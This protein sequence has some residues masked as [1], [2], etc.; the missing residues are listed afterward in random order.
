MWKE[1]DIVVTGGDTLLADIVVLVL[2]PL[3]VD[4]GRMYLSK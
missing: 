3:L 4:I 2:I 1:A